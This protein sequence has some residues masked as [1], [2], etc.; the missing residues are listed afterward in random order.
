MSSNLLRKYVT[1]TLTPA[2]G[3]GGIAVGSTNGVPGYN[4]QLLGGFYPTAPYAALRTFVDQTGA[5]Q[6]NPPSYAN[7]RLISGL[8]TQVPPISLKEITQLVENNLRGQFNSVRPYVYIQAGFNVWSPGLL[9]PIIANAQ[10][11][12]QALLNSWDAGAVTTATFVNRGMFTFTA[13]VDTY[14]VIGIAPPNTDVSDPSAI[15]FGFLFQSYK[16][17]SVLES[18]V[19]ASLSSTVY[20]SLSSTFSVRYVDGVVDYFVNGVSL[21][22]TVGPPL[23]LP[24]NFAGA[25]ALYGATS[26]VTGVSVVAYSKAAAM[27]PTLRVQRG[28]NANI[29]LKTLAVRGAR[30]NMASLMLPTVLSAGGRL[31]YAQG[32]T[33]MGKLMAYGGTNLGPPQG[34]NVVLQSIKTAGGNRSSAALVLHL[35]LAGSDS[36]L[37]NGAIT[38]QRVQA[39]GLAGRV[40]PLGTMALL[41]RIQAIATGTTGQL[42][43]GYVVLPRL[44]AYASKQAV[45]QA[46][47]PRLQGFGYQDAAN[48]AFISGAPQI[49]MTIDPGYMILLTMNFAGQITSALAASLTLSGS[50]MSAAQVASA[51]ATTS[52]IQ[53]LMQ[54]G[55]IGSSYE[56]LTAQA[57][58]TWVVNADTSASSS[59]ENYAFNSFSD[60]AGQMFAARSDGLYLLE[61][62]T[63][64]G[65]PI[66]ASL[67]FGSTDFGSPQLKRP[68]FAY[69]GVSSTGTMYLKVIVNGGT[70][71][72]YAARRSDDFLAQQRIDLGKGM[73]ASYVTFQ[74]YNSDGC[75]FELNTVR[76]EAAE[77]TRRI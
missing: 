45:A 8:L 54:A 53:A 47:L 21:R 7:Y 25:A 70:E 41:Q 6:A 10:I 34:G 68:E 69:I 73:R 36:V 39:R 17:V 46:A 4:P 28:N 61:G 11:Y 29:N 55:L 62:D 13:D 63:D 26:N 27:L 76:F 60:V 65:S 2:T 31:G 77:L 44:M 18:G 71:Y 19:P 14:A 1:P 15:P 38:M 32:L 49:R 72:I 42:G 51:L 43:E 40:K 59:Y 74:L 52:I 35:A 57:G 67:S 3:G 9:P 30:V 37:G 20:P 50:A 75:D 33:L 5:T 56:S 16:P 23:A 48:S 64:A 12:I 66:Q 24:V 22:T 58:E